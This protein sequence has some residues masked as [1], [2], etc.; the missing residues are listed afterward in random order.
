LMIAFRSAPLFHPDDLPTRVLA[1]VL[2]RVAV[3]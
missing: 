3:A 2:G 1:T